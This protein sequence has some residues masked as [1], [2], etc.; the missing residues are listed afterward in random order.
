MLDFL[1]IEYDQLG[2][3]RERTGNLSDYSAPSNIFRSQDDIWVTIPASS[4]SI[5]ERLC[6]AL[7]LPE[8]IADPRFATNADRLRHRAVLDG[9]LA[10]AI[11]FRPIAELGVLLN[12]YEVGWSRINSIADVFADE[13][14][15]A[16]EAIVGVQDDELGMVRMQNVVP[17]YSE[18][19]G[20]V[21]STGPALGEHNE[22]ILGGWLDLDAEDLARL[23][24]AGVI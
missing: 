7:A 12:H 24:R 10:D 1:A 14:F 8:L 17:V 4:Q 11:A 21:S 23:R 20:R 15:A 2:V 22:E 5:F 9:I 6:R 16:R 18:T 13:Q 3:V 19:P